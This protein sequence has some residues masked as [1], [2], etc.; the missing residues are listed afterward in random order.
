M[1]SHLSGVI[2]KFNEG[3]S[4]NL[5]LVSEINSIFKGSD[6]VVEDYSSSTEVLLLGSSDLL[7]K[8]K[9]L[10]VLD[11]LVRSG[12]KFSVSLTLLNI[13]S[14][15]LSSGSLQ[16]S[17]SIRDFSLT[18]SDFVITFSLLSLVEIIMGN[19]FLVYSIL[20]LVKESKNSFEWVT[21][22]N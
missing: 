16:N 19:L 14:I 13:A 10:L 18:E 5:N 6:S 22:L 12:S 1:L 2:S 20:E 8:F 7:D 9:M 11:E 4:S 21:S 3:S 15:E 17:A